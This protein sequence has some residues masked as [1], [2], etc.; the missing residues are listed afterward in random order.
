MVDF[1]HSIYFLCDR[2][3][4]KMID[5]KS[6]SDLE[7][8]SALREHG[9]TI[10]ITESTRPSC[11]RKLMN[12]L[13]A[14]DTNRTTVAESYEIAADD[15]IDNEDNGEAF[16]TVV[17]SQY[18]DTETVENI[19]PRQQTKPTS[20]IFNNSQLTD[21][22]VSQRRVSP[23]TDFDLSRHSDSDSGETSFRYL[24]ETERV[25]RGARSI[26][27]PTPIWKYVAYLAVA[28]VLI[29]FLVFLNRN[30][31]NDEL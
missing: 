4:P 9:L 5:V 17:E 10:P 12:L 1:H 20:S 30:A 31:Q 27:Q 21:Q 14:G 3:K 29:S 7:L 26:A 13:G 28:I 2:P 6:L 24:N 23:V 8:G 16:D 15:P 18:H 19:P 22:F 25:H 11:E